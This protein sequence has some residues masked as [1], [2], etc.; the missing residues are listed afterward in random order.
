[1][2]VRNAVGEF[3]ERTRLACWFRRHAERILFSAASPGRSDDL[4]GKFAIAGR[5]RQ[6]PTGV[7]SPDYTNT[8]EAIRR[9]VGGIVRARTHG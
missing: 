3:W 5:S 8:R 1:M 6:H 2:R 9:V 7:R 4:E